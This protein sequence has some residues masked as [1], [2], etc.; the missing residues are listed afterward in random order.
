[1]YILKMTFKILSSPP[2]MV[3]K[4]EDHVL[5]FNFTSGRVS[6]FTFSLKSQIYSCV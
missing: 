3:I 1:M 2:I 5:L 4:L 6:I